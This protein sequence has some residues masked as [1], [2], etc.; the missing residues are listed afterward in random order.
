MTRPSNRKSTKNCKRPST[1]FQINTR[2]QWKRRCWWSLRKTVWLLKLKT[3]SWAWTNFQMTILMGRSTRVFQSM[4]HQSLSGNPRP[5]QWLPLNRHRPAQRPQ[6]SSLT[7]QI[8]PRLFQPETALTPLFTK[9]SNQLVP[10]FPWIR[11]S[12]GMLYRA[13]HTNS[14][15]TNERCY[16]H[17]ELHQS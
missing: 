5:S 12:R 10:T 7:R 11:L 2:L 1:G 17:E 6:L 14:T 4:K 16:N 13:L 8:S 3:W 9:H 15:P